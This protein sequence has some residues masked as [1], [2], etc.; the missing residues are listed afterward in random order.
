MLACI[1]QYLFTSWSGG[2][3]QFLVSFL[4][5]LDLAILLQKTVLLSR[6]QYKLY[7]LA[8]NFW[9]MV[10]ILFSLPLYMPHQ[11]WALP[12]YPCIGNCEPHNG[13]QYLQIGHMFYMYIGYILLKVSLYLKW[14]ISA[15]VEM[16]HLLLEL[17]RI[18]Q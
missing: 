11:Y 17:Y 2:G 7:G 3:Y 18:F 9:E 6:N 16:L 12:L 8:I 10:F 5:M 1:L 13:C 15:C 4:I 14:T